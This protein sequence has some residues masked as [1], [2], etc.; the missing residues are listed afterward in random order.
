MYKLRKWL[1]ACLCVIIGST[2]VN[3]HVQ[4]YN[5]MDLI[6]DGK[7]IDTS[8]EKEEIHTHAIM[9]IKE[10]NFDT[11]NNSLI[12]DAQINE[13]DSVSSLYI[14]TSL[15]KS[16]LE[17]N[18]L[19]AS[20]IDMKDNF[21]VIRL[22]IVQK[23]NG[24]FLILYILKNNTSIMNCFEIPLKDNIRID[25]SKFPFPSSDI[26]LDEHWWTKVY[27]PD[28][29]MNTQSLDRMGSS[30]LQNVNATYTDKVSLDTYKYELDIV[31]YADFDGFGVGEAGEDSFTLTVKGYR[32]YKNGSLVSQNK[33]SSAILVKSANITYELSGENDIDNFQ[34]GYKSSSTVGGLQFDFSVGIL[35]I[36]SISWTPIQKIDNEG[37]HVC[38]PNTK[39][40]KLVY[41]VPLKYVNDSYSLVVNK[42]RKV[43]TTTYQ[44]VRISGTLELAFGSQQQVFTT[45]TFSL[46]G[47]YY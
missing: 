15:Y 4:A 45:K 43:Y 29:T 3:F 8:T 31:A 6:V 5:G 24:N 11:S 46:Q 47:N 7:T 2:S 33:G 9:N 13:D 23:Q 44:T 22:D 35:N 27:E 39:K 20:A 10:L 16:T 21:K 25:Y 34:P 38:L 17:N 36:G 40:T 28:V 42:E 41:N 37:V 12:L 19:F 30:R 26:E 32:Y 1:L 14:S 18:Q